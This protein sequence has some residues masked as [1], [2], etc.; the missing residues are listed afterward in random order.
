MKDALAEVHR[1]YLPR[2]HPRPP[3]AGWLAVQYHH[4][5]V[6]AP[7]SV[8]TSSVAGLTALA[9]VA[10][11]AYAVCLLGGHGSVVQASTPKISPRTLPQA[12]ANEP[13]V[14]H[15]PRPLRPPPRPAHWSPHLRRRTSHHLPPCHWPSSCCSSSFS[16]P[17]IQCVSLRSADTALYQ[18]ST[19]LSAR[20]HLLYLLDLGRRRTWL[21]SFHRMSMFVVGERQTQ[22][23]KRMLSANS[24]SIRRNAAVWPQKE[25]FPTLEVAFQNWARS[26]TL[27]LDQKET[28]YRILF[29]SPRVFSTS[30]L[31][32]S[33]WPCF[34]CICAP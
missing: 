21:L 19:D 13:Q 24:C 6:A 8:W 28:S 27:H 33:K 12:T 25:R 3:V 11:M 4:V 17:L 16:S 14:S 31:S 7:R 22:N 9:R 29:T 30:L 18:H 32:P 34:T 20:T 26:E 2:L 23:K 1:P 10:R 15:S 5:G